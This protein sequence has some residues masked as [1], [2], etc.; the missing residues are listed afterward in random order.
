V[1]AGE[2]HSLFISDGQVYGCG[3]NS[4]FQIGSFD[5]A[6]KNKKYI[7]EPVKYFLTVI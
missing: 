6:Y 5:D 1:S 2:N 7:L 3:D 4:T